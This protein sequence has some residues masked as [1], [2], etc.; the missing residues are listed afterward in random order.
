MGVADALRIPTSSL[1]RVRVDGTDLCVATGGGLG[2]TRLQ[3]AH[4]GS[5]NEMQKVYDKSFVPSDQ[6]IVIPLADGERKFV[7]I[8]MSRKLATP[9]QNAQWTHMDGRAWF[10]QAPSPRDR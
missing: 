1:D 3:M 10:E 6:A 2:I 9:R 7:A 8:V 5:G 4:C